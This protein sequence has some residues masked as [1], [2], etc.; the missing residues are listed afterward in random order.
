MRR[1]V[2]ISESFDRDVLGC[3][4]DVA[5]A[6]TLDGHVRCDLPFFTIDPTGSRDLDQAI[7]L[8]RIRSGYRIHYAIADVAAFVAPDSPLDREAHVRGVTYYSPDR[9]VPLHPEVLS[10]G[11]ASLLPGADR[12]SV[13]WTIDIDHNG[14]TT[15]THVDRKIIR[16]QRQCDY[17][18]VQREIDEG[19]ADEQLLLL[20]EIG[21][22]LETASAR[23]G[24]ID[25]PTTEQIVELVDDVPVLSYRAPV[26]AEAWNAQISL[27]CGM[28]AARMMIDRGV[29]ILRTLADP[30]PEAFAELRRSAKGL[31]F[32]WKPNVPYSGFFANL[33][34][35]DPKAAA[36]INLAPRLLRGA[37]YASFASELPSVFTHSGVGA[38]YAHCTAPLRRMA[39]RYVNEICLAITADKP[40][41][42]WVIDA[43]GRVPSE[44]NA[45]DHRANVLERMS[46]D[47]AEAA[48]MHPHVGNTFQ[49][50]VVEMS[51][52]NH[53]IVQINNPAVRAVA[54]E[55]VPTSLG[56][57][58]EVRVISANTEER[59][60][61]LCVTAILPIDPQ[62]PHPLR[63]ER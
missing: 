5:G 14:E 21:R 42:A 44:M 18:S 1:E 10:E 26:L 45:A 47:F 3:A 29:G 13:V 34:P 22:V 52:R 39:D 7:S 32:V 60:V 46:I 12:L 59:T 8:E 16:S 31:G 15:S 37:S 36:L 48:V 2:G 56:D 4:H 38:P 19:I 30:P 62:S 63:D 33:D 17:S 28:S 25:L 23:R 6:P 9:N 24:A 51:K 54:E 20:R 41:P 11:A 40:I 53:P 50:V 55:G 43:L 35:T 61:R 27:L 58:V 49:G 57:A